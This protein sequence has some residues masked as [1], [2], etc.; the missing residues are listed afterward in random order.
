M[1]ADRVTGA[2]PAGAKVVAG[3]VTGARCAPHAEQA[4]RITLAAT[5]DAEMTPGW[6]AASRKANATLERGGAW[7]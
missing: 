6:N 7:A 4:L 2:E 5:D 3:S 1:Q